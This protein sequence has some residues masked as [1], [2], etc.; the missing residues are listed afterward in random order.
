MRSP[1]SDILLYKVVRSLLKFFGK[2]FVPVSAAKVVVGAIRQLYIYLEIPHINS[3]W[4]IT[5]ICFSAIS[6]LEIT[7]LK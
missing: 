7:F 6:P 2:K 5:F 4:T 3:V 1:G